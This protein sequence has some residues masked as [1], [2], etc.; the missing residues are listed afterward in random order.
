M[1][2][3][4]LAMCL[5]A[6]LV[7]CGVEAPD[8]AA[9]VSKEAR[10]PLDTGAPEQVAKSKI[11][12]LGFSRSVN[13]IYGI[14]IPSGMTPAEGPVRVLRFR[15]KPSVAQVVDS[16]RSQVRAKD[17]VREG[18]G[19]L[20][21]FARAHKDYVK[22]DLAIRVFAQDGATTLDIWKEHVYVDKLP[23]KSGGRETTSSRKTAARVDGA[24]AA[25]SRR[26]GLSDAMRIMHK[27]QRNEPLTEDE[28]RSALFN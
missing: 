1:V 10:P 19:F 18:E 8:G 2:Y 15:G 11:H 4:L 17:E 16:I 12:H 25:R 28:K 7:A 9:Q 20:F 21:R 26:Q 3:R 24:K 13:K 23:E 5:G 6:V 14:R 22:R 27:M